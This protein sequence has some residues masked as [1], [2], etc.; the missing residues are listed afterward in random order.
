[1]DYDIFKKLGNNKIRIE[2]GD[3]LPKE[4][5]E[6]I[7]ERC[8]YST[9]NGGM[10]FKY[11][12]KTYLKEYVDD[13]DYGY[14]D[15]K[16]EVKRYWQFGTSE[17]KH[18]RETVVQ[19]NEIEKYGMKVVVFHDNEIKRRDGE[20][21]TYQYVNKYEIL[22]DMF[23]FYLDLIEERK[24]ESHLSFRESG[25]MSISCKYRVQL[26]F[27]KKIDDS[28]KV[29][30]ETIEFQNYFSKFLRWL[31]EE[32]QQTNF[33]ISTDEKNNLL[34]SFR[35][36]IKEG[37]YVEP[38]DV[39]RRNFFKKDG[40]PYVRENYGVSYYPEGEIC[41]LFI[42][43]NFS[44]NVDGKI[45]IVMNDRIINT[46]REV[47]GYENSICEGYYNAQKNTFVMTDI[48][49][50]RGADVRKTKFFV[51]GA[52]TKE[53]MRHE[54][55]YQFFRECIQK[56]TYIV[57]DLREES[58]KIYV[59]KYLFGSGSLFEDNI[60][61]LFEKM[62]FQ[63]Y[64]VAGIIFRPMADFYPERSGYWY[65]CMRW[66]YMSARTVD[67]LV[68]YVREGKNDKVSPFQLPSKDDQFGRIIY[69]KTLKLMIVGASGKVVDFNPR[70]GNQM[71]N[72][73]NVPLHESGRVIV[74]RGDEIENGVVVS[75]LYQRI[76]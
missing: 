2:F 29:G 73:A 67:F 71:T 30:E 46:G 56:S 28:I 22:D 42:T 11:E 36:F 54:Y 25:C 8:I 33:I 69:Y 5:F 38:V 37:F 53:K 55:M 47:S 45:F 23:G 65:E 72:I 62:S 76:Y 17:M 63:E 13:F 61:E 31:F 66:R 20:K 35:R 41:Y 50:Y 26:R 49:Y 68:S 34:K 14:V 1:M 70:G 32:I 27:D 15:G 43:E 4:L 75:F 64:P 7:V 40:I 12:M 39:L 48:L 60:N 3:N 74:S 24:I 9:E 52:G 16:D 44:K 18:I 21:K 10:N 51:M 58:T 6:K 59:G 57:S 19:E